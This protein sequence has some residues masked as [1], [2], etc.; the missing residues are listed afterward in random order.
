[1]SDKPKLTLPL[2]VGKRYVRRDGR[3]I[4]IVSDEK[5]DAPLIYQD[6]F[7]DYHTYKSKFSNYWNSPADIVADYVGITLKAHP[8]AANMMLYAQDAAETD[9]P[10]ERW[11]YHPRS[12]WEN[13]NR[14]PGWDAH[15]QYRRKPKTIRIGE[16][17]IHPDDL[18]A[19]REQIQQLFTASE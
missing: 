19:A 7:G 15:V 11:E 1:M 16:H 5:G 8:H 4:S 10:W 14:H 3:V 17:D 2:E 18:L 12:G 6:E 9:V 13:L